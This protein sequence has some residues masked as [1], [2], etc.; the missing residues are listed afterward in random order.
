MINRDP[1]HP[2]LLRPRAQTLDLGVVNFRKSSRG[3]LAHHNHVLSLFSQYIEYFFNI[4]IT[5]KTLKAHPNIRAYDP[6]AINSTLES[7]ITFIN[8][9]IHV[10]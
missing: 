10:I 7:V 5:N 3:H 6:G 4:H 1:Q 8:L 9:L 2:L